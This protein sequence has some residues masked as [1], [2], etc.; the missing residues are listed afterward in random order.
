[1]AENAA[2]LPHFR[3]CPSMLPPQSAAMLAWNR[4][5]MT[6]E[7]DMRQMNRDRENGAAN[8]SG[9]AMLA[10]VAVIYGLLVSL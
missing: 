9:W 4:T 1:M 10:L 6:G 3:T 2:K 7:D 8:L 5:M